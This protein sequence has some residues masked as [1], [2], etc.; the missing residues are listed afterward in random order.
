MNGPLRRIALVMFVLFGAL[1]VNI[2]YL[3]VLRADELANDNRNTRKLIEEYDLQRG[4]M[5]VG[6]GGQQ[7]EIARSVET[8]GR[9]RFERRYPEG[10]LYA[11][12]TGFYSIVYGRNALEDTANDLLVGDAPEAFA[13]NLSTFLAGRERQG[14]DIVLT[15]QPR[16]QEAAREALGDREG[17]VVALNPRNGAV[18]AVWANPTY[19]PNE[20]TTFDRAAATEYWEATE[21]ARRNRA[22]RETYPPGS[23]FKL[24][25]AAAALEGGAQPDDTFPDPQDYTPPLTTRAIPNFGGGLCNG[26]SPLTL[27]QALAVSCNTVFARLGND[28]GPEALVE[29]AERFGL[30]QD[31]ES[32]LNAVPSAIPTELDPPAT[33]QSAIGQ[34]DVRVTPLQM[35][36]ISA[37]IAND[38]VLMRPRVIDRVQQFDGRVV[39]EFDPE[40]LSFAGAD[41][42][43]AIS[44]DTAAALQEMMHAVVT[45]GSGGGAAIGGVEVAGKT[46]TAQVAAGTNPTV[47]F[48]GFA[49]LNDP[50]VAVAVVVPNGG[51]VGAE[52]TGGAVAAP[53][54]GAVMEAA[55]Q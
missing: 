27:T 28:V 30:N 34:R 47:W 50:E 17:A 14:D 31:W 20:L 33:A 11:H 21:Q 48:T 35:A 4:S 43:Q 18:L 9:Y 8:D 32:F 23:T 38:G 55:L 29:Q 5:L 41:D 49:P 45:N 16:V 44:A 37:A 54:A 2:N 36:M 22:L 25:T 10:E 3:Q 1:F 24:V 7:V 52:A 13:R 39:R 15:I 46:G 26:G 19:D 53:I 51:D 42:G 12:L 40:P 6:R